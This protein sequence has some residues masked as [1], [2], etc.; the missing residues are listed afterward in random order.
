MLII[1]SGLSGVGKSAIARE[2]ARRMHAVYLCVD[3][4]EEALSLCN[5]AADMTQTAYVT[6]YELAAENVSLGLTVIAD[7]VN[8][9]DSTRQAWHDMAKRHGQAYLDVEVICSDEAEHKRRVDAR[10]AAGAGKNHPDWEAVCSRLYEPWSMERLVI[11]SCKKSV[12]QAA[13]EIAT[14]A[15]QKGGDLL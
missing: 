12:E 8:A 1:F 4:I 2:L 6:G 3:T 10:L 13:D 11:D 5:C 9:L 15:K 7:S 14:V